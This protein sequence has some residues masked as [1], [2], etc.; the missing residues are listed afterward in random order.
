VEH[1]NGSQQPSDTALLRCLMDALKLPGQAPVYFIM[2]ALDEC[3]NTTVVPSPREN[4]VKLVEQ[5]IDSQL[6]NLHICV[7]GRPEIDI[8]ALL[9][10]LAFHSISLHDESG[11]LEDIENYIKSAVNRD[12]RSRKPK[13]EDKQLVRDVL[14][15]NA[16]GM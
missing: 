12:P 1:R 15:R 9:G 3:P 11:Q 2:N 7:T 16:H 6:P 5:L 13:A 8:N 14:I 10:P 4:V